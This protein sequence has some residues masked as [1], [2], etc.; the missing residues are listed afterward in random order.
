MNINEM[1]LNEACVEM[2][3]NSGGTITFSGRT[4]W[5]YSDNENVSR[6]I[7][8]GDWYDATVTM[9]CNEVTIEAEFENGVT[10]ST[11]WT[12]EN[13]DDIMWGIMDYLNS[14]VRIELCVESDDNVDYVKP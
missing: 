12:V 13:S 7:P 4:G 5:D 1:T 11:S 10:D 3:N 9:R 6:L 8:S 2:F 14:E